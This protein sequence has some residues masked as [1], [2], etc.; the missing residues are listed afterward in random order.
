M[1]YRYYQLNFKH[2]SHLRH[3]NLKCSGF[4]NQKSNMAGCITVPITIN[5][6][7]HEAKIYV[8]HNMNRTMLLGDELLRKFGLTID[9]ANDRVT[10]N[11]KIV[12]KLSMDTRKLM[13]S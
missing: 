9:Y 7:T 11:G 13:A 8:V 2:L 3:T 1:N 6:V 10:M 4:A 5:G 12:K